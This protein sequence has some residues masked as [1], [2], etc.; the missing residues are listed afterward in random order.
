MSAKY[1]IGQQVDLKIL[2]ETDMGFVAE[3]NHFDE[4]LI[5]FNEIFERLEIDQELPGFIKKIRPDGAID[6]YLQPLKH[7]GSEL[8]GEHILEA[9]KQSGGYL[10][11]NAKSKAELIYKYFGVSRNKF[12][13]ALGGL[14][15]KRLVTFTDE[16]TQL[17]QR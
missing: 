13:M 2:R 8:L 17:V 4:G 10:P 6:L 3:I 11:I 14:Y 7:E 1:K 5:Y 9:L 16:G 15:K 12:K